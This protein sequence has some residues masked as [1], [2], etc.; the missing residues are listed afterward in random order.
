VDAERYDNVMNDAY[1]VALYDWLK[2]VSQQRQSERV[3]LYTNPDVYDNVLYPTAM[4]LWGRDV[5]ADYELWVAQYYWTV[6]P[7]GEPSM[8]TRKTWK[9]WQISDAGDPLVHGTDG[10]CDR[11]VFNGGLSELLAW[12]G[13]GYEPEPPVG[14]DEMAE[15]L[16]GTVV[17]SMLNVRSVPSSTGN[18]PVRTITKDQHVIAKGK[19]NGWW[20]LTHIEN[21]RL[22]QSLYAFEGANNGYIRQDD[23]VT[24]ADGKPVIQ[25]HHTF[26]AVGYSDFIVSGEWKPNA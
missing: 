17:T 20:E 16:L 25:V 19:V 24:V 7:D 4:R 5:F 11:N 13:V 10:W 8:K 9:F 21:V 12:A 18:T 2:Y 22:P 15:L 26:S 6:N 14:G 1:V 23:V 3:L